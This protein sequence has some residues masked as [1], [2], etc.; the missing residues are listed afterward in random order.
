MKYFPSLNGPH[1]LAMQPQSLL[2]KLSGFSSEIPIKNFIRFRNFS[3]RKKIFAQKTFLPFP[4]DIW[5]ARWQKYFPRL[6]VW[7]AH[8]PNGH[9]ES[10][11]GWRKVVVSET[12]ER[13]RKQGQTDKAEKISRQEKTFRFA[14]WVNYDEKVVKVVLCA[15]HLTNEKKSIFWRWMHGI[16][17]KRRYLNGALTTIPQGTESQ[18]KILPSHWIPGD[19]N[20]L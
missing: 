8:Q 1:K 10:S 11:R 4:N 16:W 19:D 17:H 9:M 6:R 5:E 14:R 18:K 20:L 15:I 2:T 7:R 3:L 13:F 12:A